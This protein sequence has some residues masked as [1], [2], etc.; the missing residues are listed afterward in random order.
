MSNHEALAVWMYTQELAMGAMVFYLSIVSGYLVVAYLAGKNLTKS[1]AIFISSLF[2]VFAL[3]ALWGSVAYFYMGSQYTEH[4]T[5]PLVS[6]TRPFGV[7]PFY[8]IGTLQFIG[9]IASL[10]FM[11]DVRH[12]KTE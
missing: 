6:Q 9:I 7:R 1:Q 8:I 5:V 10:R 11:W 12:D 4:F 2:T 3:F